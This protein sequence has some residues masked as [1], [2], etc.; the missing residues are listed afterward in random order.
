MSNWNKKRTLLYVVGCSAL[1]LVAVGAPLLAG[2]GFLWKPDEVSKAA[3]LQRSAAV[4]VSF[5]LLAQVLGNRAVDY[6]LPSRGGFANGELIV[7]YQVY[8][9]SFK[10]INRTAIVLTVVGSVVWGYGDL[11]PLD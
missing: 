3:W 2:L 6:L 8:A 5:A 4:T 11:L 10:W 1:L 7:I 9:T